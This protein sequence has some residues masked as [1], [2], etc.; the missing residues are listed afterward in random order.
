MTRTRA[1]RRST[2]PYGLGSATTG[3][4]HHTTTSGNINQHKHRREMEP[5]QAST[6]GPLRTSTPMS[7]LQR[8]YVG[9]GLG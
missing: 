7:E 3:T 9:H 2:S 4:R 1:H 5:L 6:V 8:L